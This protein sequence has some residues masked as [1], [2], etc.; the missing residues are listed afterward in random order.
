MELTAPPVVDAPLV[1]ISFVVESPVDLKPSALRI[2]DWDLSPDS[3]TIERKAPEASRWKVVARDVP[4]TQ[5]MNE[6]R[7]LARNADGWSVLTKTAQ[8]QVMLPPPPRA[9]IEFLSPAADRTVETPDLDVRFAI[10]STSRLKR[11]EL[12]SGPETVATI[13]VDKQ[14]ANEPSAGQKTAGFRLEGAAHVK[15]RPRDNVLR[16]VA[17]NDGGESQAERV[18]TYVRKPVEVVVDRLQPTR[19]ADEALVPELLEGGLLRFVNASPESSLWLHGRVRWPDAATQ[20]QNRVSVV[21]VWVNGFLQQPVPLKA[22]SSPGLEWSWRAKIRLNRAGENEISVRLPGVAR[23][24]DCRLDFKVG[25]TKPDERQRLHLLVV[26]VGEKDTKQLETLALRAVR[27][28]RM[29]GDQIATPAFAKGWLYLVSGYVNRGRITAQL[30]RIH[31]R[32]G[33]PVDAGAD[34]VMVYYRGQESVDDRGQFY[35]LTSQ[36]QFDPDT[37]SSAVSG[38]D[39]SERFTSVPGAQLFLLDVQRQMQAGDPAQGFPTAM[40]WPNEP[41]MAALRYAWLG[42]EAAPADARLL[43][44]FDNAVPEATR[45]GEIETAVSRDSER[46][47]EKY[48]ATFRYVPQVPESLR[49]L[50]LAKPAGVN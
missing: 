11:V 29:A 28:R 50:V 6:I 40:A 22:P 18:V 47:R 44:A 42:N 43:V 10:Q 36:S 17:I 2:N 7:P 4:L 19:D 15:L 41:Q 26:G 46:V 37:R 16:L 27:G 49:S 21:Q 24:A 31:L 14:V 38:R 30:E 32:V 33:D 12:R 45:L 3:V 23:A 8:V 35:L 5:G 25:C 1:E 9:E 20:Q 48:G 34:V 39:L 13:D